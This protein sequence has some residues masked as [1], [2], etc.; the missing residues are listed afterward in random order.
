MTLPSEGQEGTVGRPYQVHADHGSVRDD[1]GGGADQS[2]LGRIGPAE[3]RGHRDGS[4]TEHKNDPDRKQVRGLIYAV[5]QSLQKGA[6][7]T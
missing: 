1:A 6:S 2:L 5:G 4:G 3:S 7:N